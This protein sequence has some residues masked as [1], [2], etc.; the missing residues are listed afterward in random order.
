[1]CRDLFVL[2]IYNSVTLNEDYKEVT[3][4]ISCVSGL[5]SVSIAIGCILSY[6]DDRTVDINPY[7]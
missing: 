3:H 7:D 2:L 4:L 5:V 6:D 1:M